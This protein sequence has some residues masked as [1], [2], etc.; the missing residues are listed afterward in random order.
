MSVSC[1][2]CGED[3]IPEGLYGHVLIED[4]EVHSEFGYLPADFEDPTGVDDDVHVHQ[5]VSASD[6]D[7]SQTEQTHESLLDRL[8]TAVLGS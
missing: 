5:T 7:G 4:D 2:Y 3:V 6:A 8:T 1:P